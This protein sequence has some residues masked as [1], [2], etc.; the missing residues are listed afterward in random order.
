MAGLTIAGSSTITDSS[1]S[2]TSTSSSPSTSELT[3]TAAAPSTTDPNSSSSSSSLSSTSSTSGSAPTSTNG[4]SGAG[5]CTEEQA[6]QLFTSGN[7]TGVPALC[8]L[9]GNNNTVVVPAGGLN[10]LITWWPGAFPSSGAEVNLRL[11]FMDGS[12]RH[13]W[14]VNQTAYI[15]L[16]TIQITQENFLYGGASSSYYRLILEGSEPGIRLT[17]EGPVITFIKEDTTLQPPPPTSFNFLGVVVGVPIAVAVIVAVLGVF[18]CVTNRHKALFARIKLPTNRRGY[19]VRQSRRQRMG[20]PTDD[21]DFDASAPIYRDD[22]GADYSSSTREERS[23]RAM[24][25]FSAERN[26][27]SS[28]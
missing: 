28:Y 11:D 10:K 2:S 24:G 22:P 12:G 4:P 23:A 6:K 26:L 18:C 1:I 15:G 9:S 8:G 5:A 17:T 21:Y 14:S 25:V 20:N 19:G 16:V 3:T 13:S 7:Y 27:H